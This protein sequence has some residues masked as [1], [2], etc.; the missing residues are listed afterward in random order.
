MN[1]TN[2][3]ILADG[4]TTVDPLHFNMQYFT[5]NGQRMDYPFTRHSCGSAACALGHGPI[6]GIAPLPNHYVDGPNS[7][8]DW[9]DYA[10]DMFGIDID[11]LEDQALWNY[12][13]ADKW[14]V[15][16]P[17]PRDAADRIYTVLNGF[18]PGE[19]YEYEDD[20]NYAE[21][22][23]PP[24]PSPLHGDAAPASS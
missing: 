12:L 4:L 13:F 11:E 10:R 18:Y 20:T 9:F 2:L 17:T 15:I 24:R 16:A 23:Q 1:S 6:F 8:I 7:G 21:W 22:E 19:E 5:K 3:R 14:A